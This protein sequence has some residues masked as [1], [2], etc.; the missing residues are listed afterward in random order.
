M[1][2]TSNVYDWLVV[3]FIHEVIGLKDS[4]DIFK[5][6]EDVGCADNVAVYLLLDEIVEG[7]PA[8][9]LANFQLHLRKLQKKAEGGF[10]FRDVKGFIFDNRDK[11]C[12][13]TGF[14]YIFSHATS[15][16][17]ALITFSHGA[18]YGIN[19]DTG[20]IGRGTPVLPM[21]LLRNQP[22]AIHGASS[23]SGYQIM[24]N[25]FYYFDEN[26]LDLLRAMDQEG[27]RL[28]N[29][30]SNQVNQIFETG[31]LEKNANVLSC[32]NFQLLP[33]SDLAT[34]LEKHLPD[35]QID[36][37][38]CSNCFIQNLDACFLLSKK[39][40]LLIGPEDGMVATSYDFKELAQTLK[41]QPQIEPLEL[42]RQVL[43]NSG[44]L[45]KQSM[46]QNFLD[47][48]VIY[49]NDLTIIAELVGFIEN[50]L[51]EITNNPE[52]TFP[53]VEQAREKIQYVSFL[54]ET[55]SNNYLDLVDMF[56]LLDNLV[57]LLGGLVAKN[58]KT[59]LAAIRTK[60]VKGFTGGDF[61]RKMDEENDP[62]Y[63]FSGISVFF[64]ARE[65]LDKI[66]AF[67]LCVLFGK[68]MPPNSW[69]DTWQRFIFKFYPEL[70]Q[71][72]Q[73]AAVVSKA[74]MP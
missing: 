5:E 13:E 66:D 44:E 59:E 56:N 67:P 6:F 74:G 1:M 57:D 20:E 65:D 70:A 28:L 68:I 40:N 48:Q 52:S 15:R 38:I 49:L 3:I 43:N 11:K 7:T 34:A 25:P 46:Q 54:G 18:A 16:K 8:A 17:R 55:I 64:P 14:E 72:A 53:I 22:N 21:R 33:I 23:K 63:G 36:L 2:E 26:Q 29:E 31:K 45:F 41:D 30:G 58:Y 73:L 50:I 47:R 42:G 27:R 24:E 4:D 62:D 60:M 39:V 61:F 35:N 12:W 69:K 10:E 51:G 32:G 37:M 71:R 9:P 19:I